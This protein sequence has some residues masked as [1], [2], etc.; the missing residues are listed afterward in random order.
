MLKNANRPFADVNLSLETCQN[1]VHTGSLFRSGMDIV[2]GKD[3]FNSF[4]RCDEYYR[5]L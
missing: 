5:L 2:V 4:R 3:P 1:F